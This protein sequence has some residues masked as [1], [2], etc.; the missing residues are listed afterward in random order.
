MARG[1]ADTIESVDE[2]GNRNL[3][4]AAA[5]AGVRHFVFV[6]ALGASPDHPMPLL[7][8]KGLTEERLRASGM[9]WT[10]LQPNMYMETLP[11][12]VVGGPAL[13]GQPVTL[14][15]EGRRRHSFVA[16]HD[17]AAYA[18]AALAKGESENQ[19]L[20]IGGPQPLSLQDIVATFA[21]ELGRDIPVRTLPP[22]TPVPGMPDAVSGLL[23]ALETYDSPIDS[24]HWQPA[25]ASHPRRWPTSSATSSQP[26][27]STSPDPSTSG[28][29]AAR[30][31]AHCSSRSRQTPAA[32]S[33]KG[34]RAS[35][36]LRS[37]CHAMPIRRGGGSGQMGV[38]ATFGSSSST[39]SSGST[40]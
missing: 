29:H 19:T 32:A 35:G 3:I 15:G 21:Q 1:G 27:A 7:R 39:V 25:T 13:A 5:S 6:S 40:A 38:T 33:T 37:G 36:D 22:G 11:L 16:I 34:R 12:A 10:A 23:T 2:R 31:A 24:R 9:T 8:A 30:D 14:V 17:V 4:D 20:V 26:A 18:V 28:A